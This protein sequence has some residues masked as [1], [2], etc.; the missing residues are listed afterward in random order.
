MKKRFVFL[1]LLIIAG[2]S[3]TE[4]LLYDSTSPLTSEKAYSRSTSLSVNIPQGWFTAEDN[5]SFLIDLWLIEDNYISQIAFKTIN[6][7][8]FSS[9][10]DLKT[11]LRFSKTQK[12]VELNGKYKEVIPDENFFINTIEFV[13]Y[14][15]YGENGLPV[16]CVLFTLNN[17]VFEC[18]AQFS[19]KANKDKANSAGLFKVQNSVLGSISLK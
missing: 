15:Y 13:S 11:L 12:K 7:T 16:R 14:Q 3:K 8:E 17:K 6:L 19:T 1:I 4:Q 18:I 10:P 9:I 2:C 5:D